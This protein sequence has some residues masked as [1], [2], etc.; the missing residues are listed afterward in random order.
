MTSWLDTLAMLKAPGLAVALCLC[1]L[2][3]GAEAQPAQDNS[4]LKEVQIAA[5]AFSLGDPVPAW[6]EPVAI[7]EAGQAYPVVFRLAD[8]QYLIDGAPVIYVRRALM[9]NDAASLSSAG[10]ISI[11]FVPQYHRLK[12][13]AVRL[14]RKGESLD[15]TA[16]ST[17]RFLQRETALEQGLYSG[18]VTASVLV[19]DLRVGDTLEFAYSLHGQNPVFG[20]KFIET[21]SWDQ[22]YPTVLRR[23]VLNHRLGRPISWRLIGDRKSKPVL[24]TEVT[25]GEMRRLVFE[26]RAIGK[27]DVE[28]STPPSYLAHRRMQFSEFSGWDDVVAW[29]SGLFQ[30]QGEL[31]EDIREIIENL[32]QRPT[33]E[34]RAVAALEF[35]QSEIRYFSVSLGESSHRPTQPD[36]VLKQR[37]GDC[38][39]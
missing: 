27:V 19:S 26:E 15:R 1:L 16:S 30:R 14:F 20:D 3:A 4:Q 18:E 34:E 12:L 2:P 17:V 6:V 37:Y 8:N 33:Q 31:T 11:P 23:I 28:A 5:G 25:R 24:P 36:V 21:A 39:D 29:A 9:V 10:Q 13:H 32:R 38:K 35:V 22:T 7:P